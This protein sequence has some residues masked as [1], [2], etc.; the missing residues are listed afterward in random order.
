[1][2]KTGIQ[3]RLRPQVKYGI[4]CA[5]FHETHNHA[6]ISVDIP[7]SEFHRYRAVEHTTVVHLYPCGFHFTPFS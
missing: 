1:M 2:W 4:H 3:I 6:I 5:D 7:C